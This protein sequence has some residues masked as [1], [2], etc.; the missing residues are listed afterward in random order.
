MTIEHSKRSFRLV[1][2]S[3]NK[4]VKIE[5]GI[6]HGRPMQAA[7]KA[8]NAYCRKAGLK[9]CNLRFTIQEITR[10]SNNKTFQYV[11]ERKKLSPPK[12]IERGGTVYEV[13]FETKVKR[14]PQ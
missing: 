11:G 14:A 9:T 8:F 4:G 1:A 3:Q 6:Y 2:V 13:K 5:D 7:K 12:K 10:G